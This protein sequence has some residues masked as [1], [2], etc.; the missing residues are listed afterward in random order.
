MA[1]QIK[2]DYADAYN[3]RGIAYD[4]K[5]DYDQAISDYNRAIRIKPDYAAAYSN[6]SKTY[7]KIG[8]EI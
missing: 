8:K 6:L 5:G 2:P 1:I 4:K 7:K 3:N